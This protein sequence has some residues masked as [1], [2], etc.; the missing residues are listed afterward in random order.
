[1]DQS[2][3]HK[4]LWVKQGGKLVCTRT[5]LQAEDRLDPL[6][7]RREM[8]HLIRSCGGTITRGKLLNRRQNWFPNKELAEAM[9]QMM[10]DEGFG[11]WEAISKQNTKGNM[12]GSV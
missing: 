12:R 10:V 9:L 11:W 2:I 7:I 1:M 5:R 8:L 4:Q 6:I 3:R